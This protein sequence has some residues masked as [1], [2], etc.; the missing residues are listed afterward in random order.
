MPARPHAMLAGE[1]PGQHLPFSPFPALG[2]LGCSGS[3]ADSCPPGWAWPVPVR[4]APHWPLSEFRTTPA[5]G[6][7]NGPPPPQPVRRPQFCYLSP[8]GGPVVPSGWFPCPSHP[9]TLASGVS[10]VVSS[11]TCRCRSMGPGLSLL[12][13]WRPHPAPSLVSGVLSGSPEGSDCFVSRTL[14]PV[15][16][17]P[18]PGRK[19][20]LSRI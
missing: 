9:E 13:G 15:Q 2:D 4:T 12:E 11:V 6:Q 8:C 5:G 20:L 18:Q 1:H 17:L 7:R 10:W 16:P 19:P 3:V 14:E